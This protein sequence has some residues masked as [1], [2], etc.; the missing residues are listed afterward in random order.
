MDVLG[1]VISGRL[2]ELPSWR[3]MLQVWTPEERALAIRA[4]DRLD[5]AQTALQRAETLSGGQQQ[6]V[7]IARALAQEPKIMLADEPIASLDPLNA[8]V[9]M[10]ALRDIN[11]E[12]GITVLCTLHT[13][14]TARTYCDRVV[15]MMHGRL[16]FDG[17]PRELD[18]ATVKRIYGV[19]AEEALSETV[20]ST[21]LSAAS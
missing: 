6:R 3:A 16:V 12:D 21:Q 15:G 1:N 5:M 17:A 2:F 13:L 20:T 14:D 10:D 7:A 18:D 8:K 19:E 9:V 11:R 4:L